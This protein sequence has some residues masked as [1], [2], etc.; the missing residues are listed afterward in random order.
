MFSLEFWLNKCVNALESS[1]INSHKQTVYKP[2]LGF[3]K[4]LCSFVKL[5]FVL[6]DQKQIKKKTTTSHQ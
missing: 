5:E 3:N 1:L 2:N 4:L 6:S